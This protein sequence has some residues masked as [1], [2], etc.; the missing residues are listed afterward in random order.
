[1]DV[2]TGLSG[3]IRLLVSQPCEP[4]SETL[5]G[6]DLHH[7]TSASRLL[8]ASVPGARLVERWKDP[9]DLPATRATIAEFLA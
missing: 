9:A 4:M 6:A 1:M 2:S 3:A 8:A 5:Q 7:P